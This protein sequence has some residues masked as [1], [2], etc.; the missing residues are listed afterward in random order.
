MTSYRNVI[1]SRCRI[2]RGWE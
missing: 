1:P 2:I